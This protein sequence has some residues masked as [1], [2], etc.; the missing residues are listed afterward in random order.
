MF[1]SPPWGGLEYKNSRDYSLRKMVI[2]DIEKI[3]KQS[4]EIGKNLMFYLPRN[5]DIAELFDII[6]EVTGNPFIFLD[7]YI[8]ESANKIKAILLLYGQEPLIS[9][10]KSDI[11]NFIGILNL[12]GYKLYDN[13][14]RLATRNVY[15]IEDEQDFTRIIY[16]LTKISS[17]N[18]DNISYEVEVSQMNRLVIEEEDQQELLLK[19]VL[20]IGIQN[21]CEG[22]LK[23]K[24]KHFSNDSKCVNS[25]AG[26]VL[27]KEIVKFFYTEILT[28]KQLS[29]IQA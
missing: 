19:I 28:D 10:I 21:F 26:K 5:I 22:I 1:L 6:Y 24:E 27:V 14:D 7:T 9:S 3:T 13:K 25:L 23:L 29:R 8:L 16:Q 11:S 18:D 4:L 12:K 20:V 2:P 15:K 17:T